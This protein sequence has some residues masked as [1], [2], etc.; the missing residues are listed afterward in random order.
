[1]RAGGGASM[2]RYCCGAASLAIRPRCAI[3]HLFFSSAGDFCGI[4][5]F[6]ILFV[7]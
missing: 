4:W 3:D 5:F 6:I 2:D 7:T 1:M